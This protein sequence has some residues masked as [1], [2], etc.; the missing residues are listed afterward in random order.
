MPGC[1]CR[2]PET[3]LL[4]RALRD[5][6]VDATRSYFVGDKDSDLECARRG[7]VRGVRAPL[8]SLLA[9]L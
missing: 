2:K 8:A 7:R 5:F 9:S 6:Q 1:A 4:L 3:Q